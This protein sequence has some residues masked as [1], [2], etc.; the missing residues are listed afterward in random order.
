LKQS[1]FGL[2]QDLHLVTSDWGFEP[3]DVTRV[4]HG[5]F[6]IWHGDEDNLVPIALQRMIKNLVSNNGS[7]NPVMSKQLRSKL[8]ISIN[9]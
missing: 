7:V 5:P 3:A 8:S 6:H 4:Y 9:S 2:A 1:G